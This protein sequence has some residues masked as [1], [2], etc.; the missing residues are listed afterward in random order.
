MT[1]EIVFVGYASVWGVSQGQEGEVS[2]NLHCLLNDA[3]AA[4]W[5]REQSFI[6]S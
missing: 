1:F 4:H 3:F 5:L 6:K 2:V